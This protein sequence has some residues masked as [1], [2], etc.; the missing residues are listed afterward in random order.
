MIFFNSP[1]RQ[2]IRP[3][4]NRSAG[5]H[6]CSHSA[7]IKRSRRPAR[8]RGAL[9]SICLCSGA[10]APELPFLCSSLGL[11]SGRPC[12]QAID[13]SNTWTAPRR[14]LAGRSRSLYH[15]DRTTQS[16]R[17][18][19]QYFSCQLEYR[20]SPFGAS[21]TNNLSSNASSRRAYIG[22]CIPVAA[23]PSRIED[24]LRGVATG[25][26]SGGTH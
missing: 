23:S 12:F 25:R 22:S 13:R 15:P 6:I 11:V 5:F 4:S 14:P 7:K 17:G 3:Q 24:R 8:G 10:L 18:A 26:C 16:C 19:K 20:T 2:S 21:R 9:G 1:N